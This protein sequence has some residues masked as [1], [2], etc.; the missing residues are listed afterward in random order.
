MAITILDVCDF[1]K[2]INYHTKQ[3][4]VD[5]LY[6][7]TLTQDGN[8]LYDLDDNF[9]MY[10]SISKYAANSLPKNIIQNIIFNSYRIKKKEFP[11]KSYYSV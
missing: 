4:F 8:S 6:N 9:N 11:K 5:F 7:M 2:S 3:Y 1:N 10:I